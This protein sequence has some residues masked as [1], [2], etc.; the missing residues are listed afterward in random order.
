MKQ[1]INL[2]GYIDKTYTR[3]NLLDYYVDPDIIPEE[4]LYNDLNI[5][6]SLFSAKRSIAQNN[7]LF[8]YAYPIIIRFLNEIDGI[9]RTKD[10]IH[11]HNMT[12]IQN[13]KYK[14]TEIY[15]KEVLI[16]ERG[17]SSNWTKKEFS[18]AYDKLQNWWSIKGCV[19]PDLDMLKEIADPI[20]KLT[21]LSKMPHG[22][23]KGQPMAIIPDDYLLELY[24]NPK[25]YCSEAV[26]DYIRKA[27]EL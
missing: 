11:I 5:T 2:V 17:H 3:I 24:N 13:L 18:E 25:R 9:E 16:L 19:I 7:L 14:R 15:G 23:F 10:E 1:E 8:G 6:V 20:Q 26:K 12:E 22:S 21:D 27:F 4:F